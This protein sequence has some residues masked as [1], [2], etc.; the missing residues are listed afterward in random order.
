MRR[1][2]LLAALLSGCA[3]MHPPPEPP[4]TRAWEA[5]RTR[6][7]R[8]AWLYDRFETHAFAAAAYQ[9]P[10]LRVRRAEQVAAW[11]AMTAPERQKLLDAEADEAARF[12]EFL[13]AF[14]ADDSRDDD[15]GTRNSVWRVALVVEGEGEELPVEIRLERADAQMR[16]L[17]PFVGEFD[18][19]YR[20]RF[21]RWKGAP[22]PERPFLLR[23]AGPEGRLEFRF[24]P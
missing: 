14:Y 12:E 6:W 1:A 17:Y 10:D 5:A 15:L 21:P 23:I 22:L 18:S 19:V 13:V 16:E 7:S 3:F 8:R 9:A 4:E 11:R 20:I 24:G 2:L